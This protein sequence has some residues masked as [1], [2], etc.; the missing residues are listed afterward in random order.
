MITEKLYNE[1]GDWHADKVNRM[2]GLHKSMLHDVR[3]D[4]QRVGGV[5]SKTMTSSSAY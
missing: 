1:I 5:V 4:L 2:Q 3:A